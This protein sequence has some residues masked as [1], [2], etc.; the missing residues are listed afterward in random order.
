[1]KL[2]ILLLLCLCSMAHAKTVHVSDFATPNDNADDTP[3]F[4]AAI[5]KLKLAGGG[6]LVIDDGTWKLLGTVN[7]VTYGNDISYLIQGDKGA[8]IQIAGGQS[9][10]AFYIG[11]ANHAEFRD[12]IFTGSPSQQVYDCQFLILAAYTGRLTVNACQFFGVLAKDSVISSMNVETRIQ[13]TDFFGCGGVRGVVTGAAPFGSIVVRG[14]KFIDYGV[15]RNVYY[16][17]PGAPSW[18]NIE[19][20]PDRPV[21]FLTA[22]VTIEHSRFDEAALAHIRIKNVAH[23]RILNCTHNV[24]GVDFSK[25]IS[26]DR[27]KNG[28]IANGA[29][30]YSSNRRPALEL[31]N[32][33]FAKVSGLIFGNAVYLADV[34]TSSAVDASDCRACAERK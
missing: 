16:S 11:N 3:G 20:S 32:G 6:I 25:G 24:S 27:V 1:M 8:V 18:I 4:Q 34:D 29:F 23:V 22:S 21:Q 31:I 33:S 5:D 28:V 26:L 10:L 14:A 17:K 15:L 2:A 9:M 12:L 7:M 30:G 19:D 13:D